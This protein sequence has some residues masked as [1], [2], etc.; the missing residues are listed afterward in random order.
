MQFSGI[1][2]I[3]I[4]VQPSPAFISELSASSQTKTVPIRQ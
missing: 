1:K 4:F 2:Y 3:H